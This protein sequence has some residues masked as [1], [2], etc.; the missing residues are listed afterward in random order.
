MEQRVSLV[1]LGATGSARQRR[2]H[3]ALGST[4]ES[5]DRA[6]VF[7]GAGCL[8][9]TLATDVRRSAGADVVLADTGAAGALE[10]DGAVVLHRDP[11]EP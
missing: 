4:G 8:A 7:F 6:A 2:F 3:G 1:T 9:V 11:T 5:P 10:P